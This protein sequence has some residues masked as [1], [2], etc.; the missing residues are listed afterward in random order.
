MRKNKKGKGRA[1]AGASKGRRGMSGYLN[2]LAIRNAKR[3]FRDYLIYLLTMVFVGS[4]MLAFDSM[5]FSD[6]ILKISR[7]AGMM[8]AML[9]IA[10]FFIILII[11][12][13]VHYMMR[14]MAQ[15]RS[16][17]FATY[18]LLGFH[19]KQ[20]SRLFFRE[21]A[22]L[23]LGAF[24]ISILPGIFL[25]QLITTLIYAILDMDYIIKID[26]KPAAILMTA[27]VYGGSYF[28]ALFRSKRQFKKLNIQRMMY[29]E[30]QSEELKNGNKSGK[31]W[32][33]FASLAFIIL[34]GWMLYGGHFNEW[35][36]YLMIV[37]LVAAVYC[38]YVGLAAFLVG[39]IKRGSA[40]VQRGANVFL[41][42][43]FSSKV[44]TMQF[45]L[46]T[47][48]VLFM[49]ALC[50]SAGALMLNQFQN[51]QGAEK[52][53]F[54]VAA[55]NFDPD[56][57]FE[58]EKELLQKEVG[59]N[60]RLVY[61]IYQNGTDDW[62]QYLKSYFGNNNY[63]RY[64]TY[65]KLSDYNGLRQM[66]GYAPVE[67]GE[68]EYIL[69]TKKR[70]EKVLTPRTEQ[71]IPFEGRKYSCGGIY[72]EGFEQNGHNGADYLLVVKDE[73]T[74]SM[75]P[76]Y[77]LLAAQIRDE[78]PDTLRDQLLAIQGIYYDGD[79]M[80]Y[81]YG[82][83]EEDRGLGTDT[84]YMD[85][86]YV[87]VEANEVK[88]MKFLLSTII[89]PLIYMGLVFLCV[90]L[91]VLSVQQLSDAG[92]YRK[93]YG[94][95]RML[96]MREKEMGRLIMKQLLIYYICPFVGALIISGGIIG[97]LSYMFVKYSG[98][99]A[100]VWSY[101]GTS[102]LLFGGVYLVYF[103]ATYVEFRRNVR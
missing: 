41:L 4:L 94:I 33:F 60:S 43:Q 70:L 79:N 3:S 102:V 29:L 8:G 77:S 17:E 30:Q 5:I 69:H 28:L 18:L 10:T 92:K 12:W 40:G 80:E 101:F 65:I 103:L 64:D 82:E 44:R 86:S 98:V 26:L 6:A 27:A 78:A 62:N 99:I 75:T 53:P 95:L 59:I 15:R 19:K 13:L 81:D 42:R 54:D 97:F 37:G 9:G 55:Y 21:T 83:G 16:R 14:F 74:D 68:G 2:K 73:D 36:V 24:V 90:A 34:F 31:Q 50:G 72:T 58:E 61:Q 89:F 45:T 48:T 46:G 23:G 88:Q 38:L 96:G 100:P 76:Y 71:M 56:Y 32:M 66:L 85:D 22:L 91:A 25:Q 57:D 84:I 7:E 20:I 1:Y 87:Y 49:V 11:I 63:F 67:L 93:R 35:N 39:Y 47:L 52:W 51:T